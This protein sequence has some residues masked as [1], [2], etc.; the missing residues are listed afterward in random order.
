M[1]RK[2][3]ATIVLLLLASAPVW[4]GGARPIWVTEVCPGG[5]EIQL[6]PGAIVV[7]DLVV[8]EAPD[9][10]VTVYDSAVPDRKAVGRCGP[11]CLET[12]ETGACRIDETTPLASLTLS[13]SGGKHKVKTGNDEGTCVVQLNAA[14]QATGATCDDGAGNSAEANC[15]S[16][17]LQ[18]TGSGDCD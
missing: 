8:E 1:A 7:L 14:G 3:A 2:T 13:C 11:L 16:G 18:T 4:A 10:T 12:G 17:C 6:S 9:G 15:T 5:V